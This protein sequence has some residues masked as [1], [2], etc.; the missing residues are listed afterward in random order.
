MID[1]ADLLGIPY[2]LHGRDLKGF[3]CYGFLIEFERRL[4]HE[5][6]DLYREYTNNNEKDLSDNVYNIIYAN[7]LKKTESPILGDILLFYDKKGRV[8]HIGAYLKN[9]DFI[10]CDFEGVHISKL[11]TYFRHS[12]AYTWLS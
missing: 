4:G 10:H 7:K 2:V 6:I 8:C 1:I 3:D 11:S 12:E 5:M 9:D